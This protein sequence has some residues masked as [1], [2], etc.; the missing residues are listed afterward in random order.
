[1]FAVFHATRLAAAWIGQVN[2]AV[3]ETGERVVV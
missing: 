1:M 2:P 3:L